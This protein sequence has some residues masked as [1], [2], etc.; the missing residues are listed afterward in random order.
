VSFALDGGVRAFVFERAR[1]TTAEEVEDF[2]SRLRD[3]YP[4]RPEIFAP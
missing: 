2:S 3:A 4:D 1:T